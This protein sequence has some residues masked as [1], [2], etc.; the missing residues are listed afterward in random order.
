MAPDN[1]YY[2]STLDSIWPPVIQNH[3]LCFPCDTSTHSIARISYILRTGL[4]ITIQ[5]RLYL[6]GQLGREE[7]GSKAGR[8]KLTYPEHE[9]DVGS[10]FSENDL[11]N[12]KDVW[13]ASYEELRQLGMPIS[14]FDPELLV[15]PGGY[16]SLGFSPIA[17]QAN[18]ILG[19]CLLNICLHHSFLD[20][21]SGA[22]VVGAWA[23][24]CKGLQHQ[25]DANRE[26]TISGSVSWQ[27]P[28]IVIPNNVSDDAKVFDQP[29]RLPDVLQDSTAPNDGEKARIQKEDT[30]WRLLGLQKPAAKPLA[31]WTRLSTSAVVSTIFLASPASVLRLKSESTPL[32]STIEANSEG[33]SQFV[34]SFDAVAALLWRCILRARLPDLPSSD[35]SAGL[36]SRLRIPISLRPTLGISPSYPGNL[37]LNAT[38]SSPL[39]SLL[40]TSETIQAK[41]ASQIRASILDSRNAGQIL[42][43]IKLSFTLPDL[44]SRRPLFPSTT[45]EDLVLTT[46][47]DL[48]YYQQDW[49]QTFGIEGSSTAEFFRVPRGLLGG[50]CVVLPRR[51]E[52]DSRGVDAGWE[53]MVSVE[54]GQ[55]E[56]LKAD[57]E[58]GRYF[59]LVT[60]Q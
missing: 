10:I 11:T 5:Q 27:S 49:G 4:L 58:F 34:S 9:D 29:L 52:E 19:G 30:L 25:N 24:N 12:K 60:L 48:P 45:G 2:C 53:V 36:H 32:S 8:L 47:R 56:R 21:I 35:P 13:R 23:E 14:Q 40:T 7:D 51:S 37:L 38:T 22:M 42:D 50:V 3:I 44:A 15:P 18:F 31:A 20:G 43:A 17:A 39:A 41:V 28:D 16:D 26:A 33:P 55:I 1:L 59:G 46:W 54:R 6:A 57:A